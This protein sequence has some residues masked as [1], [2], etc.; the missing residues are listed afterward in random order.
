MEDVLLRRPQPMLKSHNCGELR[1]AHIGQEVTLAG[2][3]HRRRDHGGL[4]FIDLRDRSGLVQVVANP[5]VSPHAHESAA[6]CRSEY[7][8]LVRG[9]V[10]RRPPGTE[11]P[12]LPTGEVEVVARTL[13]VL[14]A[15]RT[16][17]FP[18][19]DD[20][21]VDE[22]L[23]LKYRYLDLRRPKMRDNLILRH[24]V[25]KFIRDYLDARGF[26][27]VE[28]PILTRSTPEGARDY[29]VPSR[30][31]PG[32]F[33]ALPQ[34]PQQLKQLLMVAGVEKYF[35][36]ARCFRDEDLR[37]DRQP[38]F[39]QLDLEMS[40]V[41]QDD[42]L[43]LV[44]ALITELVRTVTPEFK[45]RTPFPR[46]A[47]QE[48]MDRY[49]TDHADL[50][51][52]LELV[53]VT[54]LLGATQFQV[55]RQAVAAG[56]RIKGL[57]VPGQAGIAR[58]E[59]EELA[60]Y[61]RQFGLGGLVSVAVEPFTGRE[62]QIQLG[63]LG[64]RSPVGRHLTPAELQGLLDRFGAQAG[65][66]ILLGAGPYPVVSRGL[67][68]LREE[69]GRRLG[70]ADPN[71]LVFAWVVDFPA[72]EF[73][74]QENRWDAVHHP[75]TAPR[76]EDIPYLLTDPG[77]VRAKQYDLICNGYELGGGS[78]RITDP[79]VQ[80]QVFEV[81]GHPRGNIERQFGHLLTAFEYGVP[82]HGGIAIGLDRLVAV[83]AREPTIREVIA[84]PK[85]K[86]AVDL[87]FGAPSEV[88]P[89]QL[90]E[91]HIKVCLED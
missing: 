79:E 85:T 55:F 38:E 15:A 81:L 3:V 86:D 42:I 46:L 78:I 14:S 28:T 25:T 41:D 89:E 77:R 91:L 10:S 34:S 9:T 80:R 69:L 26:I 22:S 39:T 84:F 51:F 57:R 64:V 63:E 5:Q 74:E 20:Q 36:I 43:N 49:G 58:R 31:H 82:P 17:P 21:P 66:L 35:Q 61:V 70:L 53:D 65:D 7:V 40:F 2:W 62:G 44:E 59:V 1:P 83:L 76:D 75:F 4:I 73:K 27:E 54:D 90:K 29:L 13:E 72:F 8:I 19:A 6:L 47:Y 33:Y 24:R 30:V 71:L 12:N 67:A 16:P 11:N 37:A 87:L 23:R 60:A 50:R 48:I 32:K 52:G 18:I 56:G 88:S 45:V 68:E